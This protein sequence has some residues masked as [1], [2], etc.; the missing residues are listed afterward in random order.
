MQ[1]TDEIER[2]GTVG[3]LADDDDALLLLEHHPESLA[4]ERLIVDEENRDRRRRWRE[5]SLMTC[6]RSA[7]GSA[8]WTIHPPVSAGP[9]E[10]LPP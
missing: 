3:G 4:E 7:V 9:A 5:M 8:A 1:T 2:R 10:A 6:A